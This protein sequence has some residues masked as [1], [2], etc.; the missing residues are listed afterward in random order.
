[1]LIT[2]GNT[3]SI[4]APTFDTCGTGVL[5]TGG[6]PWI[7]LVDATST[8]SGVTFITTVYPSFIIENLNKDTNS[9]IAQ[10]PGGTVYGPASH[11]DSFTYGNTVNRNPTY[12]A[13]NSTLNRPS[14]LAPNGNYPVLPAPNY[15]NNTVSDFINIKDPSQNGGY[16]VLGDNSVDES[17]VLNKVRGRRRV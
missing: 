14:A 1:M 16:T 10:T 8:N 5:N 12:G 9:D 7:A 15:A 11:V 4:I 17:S 13:T 2:G 3:I 6:S